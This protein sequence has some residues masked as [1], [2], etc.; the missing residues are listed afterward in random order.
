MAVDT[1][2]ETAFWQQQFFRIKQ[3]QPFGSGCVHLARDRLTCSRENQQVKCQLEWKDF[4][5]LL[6]TII[7]L[8]MAVRA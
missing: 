6:D 7:L 8:H 2:V 4:S 1:T 3:V 5:L